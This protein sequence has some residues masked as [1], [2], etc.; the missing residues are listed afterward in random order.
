MISIFFHKNI[1]NILIQTRPHS[2]YTSNIQKKK[3][4]RHGRTCP[5]SCLNQELRPKDNL[6]L[7]VQS[8]PSQH[9]EIF[10]LNKEYN[11]N[12]L[13]TSKVHYKYYHSLMER[14][15]NCTAILENIG[16]FSKIKHKLP[17]NYN[18]TP[19]NFSKRNKNMSSHIINS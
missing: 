14:M 2:W 18:F 13:V 3:Q 7:E 6:S 12:L 10:F 9:R 11:W 15:W 16:S 8:Q 1:L 4:A 17:H 19:W 5:L